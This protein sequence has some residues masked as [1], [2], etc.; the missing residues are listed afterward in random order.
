MLKD[1]PAAILRTDYRPPFFFIEQVDLDFELEQAATR[2]KARLEV[3]RSSDPEAAGK[4]LMLTGEALELQRVRIDGRLLNPN[5]FLLGEESLAIASVPDK[6]VLETDVII[7]PAENTELSGL[8]VSN[9]IF[10]TQCEAEGFRR[11]TYFLDRPDVMSRYRVKITADTADFPVLL[12]NGNHVDGGTLADGRHWAEWEDPFPKPCYLFA[13]VAGRLEHIEDHFKTTSGRDVT[14]RIY[15]RAADIDKCDHAMASLKKAMDWDEKVFGLEYDLD[16]FNIVAVGDFNMGAMENKS[17][18]IFNTSYILAKPETATDTNFGNVESVVAHEYFH[19]WTGNRVTCR[20]WFQLSLKEGLTVFRD[21]QFSADMGSRAVK[22]ISD[23]RGLRASQFAEDSSPMAHPVRPEAYIEINNFYTS[24]VYNKG[25]EVIRMMQ[26]LLGAEGFR[27]GMDLYFE[28]HDGQAV[29]CDDF[30]SAMEDASGVDLG[31]FRLWY[32]Q[33]GTP[34]LNVTGH[35]DEAAKTFDL[36]V[37][38]HVPDTPGQT[39]KKP[40]HIPFAVGLLDGKGNDMPLTLDGEAPSDG[41]TTRVLDVTQPKQTFRFVDVAEKPVPSLLRDFSAPVRLHDD[42]D[43]D[44]LIFLMGHDS[45]PFN[46]WEAGQQLGVRLMLGLV[47]NYRRQEKLSLEP[48]YV[49]ALRKTLTDTSLDKAFIADVMSLPSEMYLGQNME[50]IDVD[51]IHAVRQ[52]VRSEIAHALKSELEAVYRDNVVKA[53]YF[54]EPKAVGRRSLKNSALSYLVVGDPDGTGEGGPVAR[55][56]NQFRS[57]DNMTD[58]LG[59]LSVLSHLDRPERATAMKEFYEKWR[60][61]ALAVDKWFALQAMSERAGIMQDVK[62]LLDHPAYERRNPNKVRAL[63][64]AF[65][66]NNP[67]GFHDPSGVGY[68]FLADRVLELDPVNPQVSARLVGALGRWRKYDPARQ[69]LMKTALERVVASP[70]LSKD[71]YEIVSKS[72]A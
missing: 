51:A 17:L 33:A 1:K 54:F 18:N 12:S 46:R 10:C 49:E 22:R 13:L 42:L 71:V 14:L 28:R 57:A 45:D 11:I 21:Q 52:F 19:N 7:K 4:P 5:E 61:D 16:V 68:E 38:Q 30:A 35:Y 23:V 40:M 32:S 65:C 34:D 41:A 66:F 58:E 9:G 70:N 53:P 60:G 69:A 37:E 56:L 3:S 24:T 64:G 25:A 67:A 44:A 43:D 6:F 47:E 50:Q 26:R 27:K 8:Y 15:T 2:V 20:D 63:V 31:Q 39:N 29:T 59:A 48:G 36:S 62:A 55:C 72:L